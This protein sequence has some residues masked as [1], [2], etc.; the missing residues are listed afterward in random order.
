VTI[1]RVILAL[2]ALLVVVLIVV[3]ARNTS[4]VDTDVPMPARGEAARDPLYAARRL[5]EERGATAARDR[6]LVLPRRDGVLLASNWSWALTTE[7]RERLE[8]W[9]ENG[10]RL[11]VDDTLLDGSG[12]FEAWSGIQRVFPERDDRFDPFDDPQRPPPERECHALY[13]EGTEPTIDERR[14]YTL[15]GLVQSS[16]VTTRDE[17]AWSLGDESEYYAVRT[18]VGRGSVT[19]VNAEPFVNAELFEGDHAAILVAAT[20]LRGGDEIRFLLEQADETVL[21]LAWRHG[22]P[23]VLLGLAVLVL[24]ILRSAVRFGPLAAPAERV[25]RSLAEQIRGTGQFA[26]RWGGGEALHAATTRALREAATARISAFARMASAERVASVARATGLDTEQLGN[27]I[28]YRG[29]GGSNEL[30]QAIALLETARRR[31]LEA[32]KRSKHGI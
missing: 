29:S 17:P 2:G 1:R 20:Q 6:A 24:V 26:L 4:W 12:A 16:L 21:A 3:I 13:E 10:G 28:E 11:V 32:D 25:R 27:A 22:A 15:C 7:R 5:A 9:V 30:A 18:D 14:R 19:V 8:A 23:V 31:L